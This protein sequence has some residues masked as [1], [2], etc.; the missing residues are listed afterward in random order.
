MILG[1][2]KDTLYSTRKVETLVGNKFMIIQ[3]IDPANKNEYVAVDNVGAGI[4]EIV[5]VATGSAARIGCNL[6]NCPVDA[7]IIG[8]VDAGQKF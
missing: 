4:G 1:K 6:E 7:A 2:V 3:P 5:M 8:I